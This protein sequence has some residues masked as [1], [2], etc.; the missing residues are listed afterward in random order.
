M[1]QVKQGFTQ[2]YNKLQVGNAAVRGGMTYLL[3]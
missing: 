2:V 3:P 1:K